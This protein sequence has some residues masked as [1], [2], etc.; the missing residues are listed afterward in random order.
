MDHLSEFLANIGQ[1][2]L[3]V[4]GWAET[5][6]FTTGSISQLLWLITSFL[7]GYATTRALVRRIDSIG[8]LSQGKWYQ[9]WIHAGKNILRP[10]IIFL[11]MLVYPSIAKSAGWDT[12]LV[13]LIL[14]LLGAWIAISFITSFVRYP[15][16]ARW[17]TILAW[18]V[19]AL[20]TFGIWG[21]F[22]GQLDAL[23]VE[24]G[25][26]RISALMVIK[27]VFAFG[28]VMWG[29]IVLSRMSD[30]HIYGL[31]NLTPSLRVLISKVVRTL[32][33]IAAVL[34]G[35]N[36]LGIDLTSLALF[37]G[38][39]GVG[40]G[41][42]LQKVVS[43]FISGIILLLDRSIKPGD[44]IAI[45]ETFGWVNRLGARHVSVIT[46]DG[47]EHLIPNESLITERVENWSYSD[48]NVRIKI[49]VHIAYESD[50]RSALALMMQ[51]AS[52]TPRVLSEPKP[53]ALLKAFGDSSIALELRIWINDPANGVG[54]VIS[55]V[56]LRVWDKF[57]E[58]GI[59]IP[60]PHHVVHLKQD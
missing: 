23:S 16:L 35:L 1:W 15:I 31:T 18:T 8:L 14:N 33:I 54:N 55:D 26:T 6:L 48:R 59:A 11:V 20:N 19:A 22:V 5:H 47:K 43:N 49:P 41:F 60:Y 30:R 17:T 53:N 34:I 57:N 13:K 39:V 51:A 32:F 52:E 21:E 42:G 45:N 44:I 37:S 24:F 7:L 28:L 2:P 10:L 40:I 3:M 27:G 25:T 50:P 58:H 29:A 9:V 4:T 12:S 38:A 36:T 46:R 56:L